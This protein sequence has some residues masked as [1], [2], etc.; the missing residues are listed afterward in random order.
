M[1]WSH[2]RVRN[3]RIDQKRVCEN[4]GLISVV[5]SVKGRSDLVGSSVL[6]ALVLSALLMLMQGTS[7]IGKYFSLHEIQ[8][9]FSVKLSCF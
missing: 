7:I 3:N 4:G 6:I 2:Y 5:V 9:S 1:R 8:A